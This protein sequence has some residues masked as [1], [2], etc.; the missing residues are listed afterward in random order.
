VTNCHIICHISDTWLP[1]QWHVDVMS[2]TCACH[3]SNTWKP[4]H[5]HVVA[6]VASCGRHIST[7][8]SATSTA[9]SSLKVTWRVNPWRSRS[10]QIL[11]FGLGSMGFTPIY[12]GLRTSWITLIY[13][14][15]LSSSQGLIYDAQYMTKWNFVIKAVLWRFFTDP[16]QKIT[17][18]DR[19]IF[20]SVCFI[21]SLNYRFDSN[22]NFPNQI[23]I[24]SRKSK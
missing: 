1:S 14:K 19:H 13:D 5:R 18:I 16:W 23:W 20:C 7:S 9:T 3:V 4:H 21:F 8:S 11:G 12:D 6:T 2:A 10:S 24:H 15:N 17:V 22:L